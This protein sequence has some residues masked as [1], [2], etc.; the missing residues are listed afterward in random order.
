MNEA[1]KPLY[2]GNGGG[3]ASAA[4]H[5]VNHISLN[6]TLSEVRIDFGQLFADSNAVRSQCRLVTS[7]VHLRRIGQ[8]ISA[9]ITRYET[10]FGTIP[11]SESNAEDSGAV[12]DSNG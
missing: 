7:P 10:R 1:A 4:R 9:T 6:F 11:L 8:E 12:E 5:Y 2:D 3:T